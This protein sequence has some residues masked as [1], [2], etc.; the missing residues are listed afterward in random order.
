MDAVNLP[1]NTEISISEWADRCGYWAK[2]TELNAPKRKRRE[3]PLRAVRQGGFGRG[4]PRVA[5]MV[6]RGADRSD[7][8]H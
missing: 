2:A 4:D 7:L 6:G 1:S 3:K 8:A 5:R